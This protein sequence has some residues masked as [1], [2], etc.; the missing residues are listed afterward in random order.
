MGYS[1]WLALRQRCH[2]PD[3]LLPCAAAP[4][5]QSWCSRCR[6]H[7][8]DLI[9]RPLDYGSVRPCDSFCRASSNERAP[10]F[11]SRARVEENHCLHW[12]R[13]DARPLRADETER[14]FLSGIRTWRHSMDRDGAEAETSGN[15]C[16]HLRPGSGFERDPFHVHDRRTAGSGRISELLV[17]DIP[18]CEGVRLSCAC[19][20]SNLC[21]RGAAV[22]H[23]TS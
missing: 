8:W 1:R 2:C 14:H 7:I 13:L 11:I 9:H 15:D 5:R 10:G 22:E 21:P 12:R 20:R 23:H 16:P 4:Q 17:L 3:H 19:L 6:R 18:I